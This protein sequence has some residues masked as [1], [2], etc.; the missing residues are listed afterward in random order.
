MSEYLIDPRLATG[1]AD[2]SPPDLF[3]DGDPQITPEHDFAVYQQVDLVGRRRIRH[4]R[5]VCIGPLDE[6]D[7]ESPLIQQPRERQFQIGWHG[8]FG[9][10]TVVPRSGSDR[11][12]SYF[13]ASHLGDFE[14]V[15]L[16]DDSVRTVMSDQVPG[17]RNFYTAL[18]DKASSAAW[19]VGRPVEVVTLESFGPQPTE[20]DLQKILASGSLVP[21]DDIPF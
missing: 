2:S 7:Y 4:L 1:E 3:P 5:P 19:K 21:I 6:V 14:Q 16:I 9:G 8:K 17:P 12:V 20:E 11:P 18:H 10:I 15:P 13:P